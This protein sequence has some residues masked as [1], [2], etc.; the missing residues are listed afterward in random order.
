MSLLSCARSGRS[1]P[2]RESPGKAR[3][4]RTVRMD[5]PRAFSAVEEKV[6]CGNRDNGVN[7]IE[8]RESGEGLDV[9]W[10]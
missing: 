5:L 3:S 2:E 1:V 8:S 9:S 10:G 4:C 7:I 6:A